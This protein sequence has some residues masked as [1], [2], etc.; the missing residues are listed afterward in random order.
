MQPARRRPT[1]Q[2]ALTTEQRLAVRDLLREPPFVDL[3][4]AEI[5]ASLL[6]QG[7]YHCSIRTMYRILGRA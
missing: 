4:P 5:Y 1:P 7:T 2:R 3:A 6:D